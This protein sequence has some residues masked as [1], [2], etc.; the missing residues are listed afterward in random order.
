[1]EISENRPISW[2]FDRYSGTGYYQRRLK[3]VQFQI[4]KDMKGKK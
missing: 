2:E 4:I 1:M 3:A